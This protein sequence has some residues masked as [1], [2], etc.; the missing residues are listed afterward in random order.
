MTH[1]KCIIGVCVWVCVS[2]TQSCPALYNHVYCR[3]PDSSVYGILS[4]EYWTGQSFPFPGHRHN[5]GIEPGSPALQADSLSFEPQEKPIL[6]VINLKYKLSL[7]NS[8]ADAL[9]NY[10]I[11]IPINI[12]CTE[13]SKATSEYL[14]L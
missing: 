2:V 11:E 8:R 14:H 5:P 12:P 6:Q 3:L 4:Q 10:I 13:Y 7:F 1:T 9:N